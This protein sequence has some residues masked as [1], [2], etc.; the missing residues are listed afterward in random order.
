MKSFFEIKSL[1][2]NF[3]LIKKIISLFW[4]FT[5]VIYHKSG[6]IKNVRK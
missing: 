2:T 1:T 3:Y 4:Y 6:I 5:L